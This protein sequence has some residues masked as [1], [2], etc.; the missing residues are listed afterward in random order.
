MIGEVYQKRLLPV[1]LIST[2]L[3]AHP[4]GTLDSPLVSSSIMS[5]RCPKP[6]G[7]TLDEVSKKEDDHD[8]RH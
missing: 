5:V 4:C 7:L 8:D 6:T 3:G 1:F 2:P